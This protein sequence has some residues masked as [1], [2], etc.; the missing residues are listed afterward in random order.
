LQTSIIIHEQ[1]PQQEGEKECYHTKDVVLQEG[2]IE[3]RR[4]LIVQLVCSVE[5]QEG[6]AVSLNP[7][8]TRFLLL[9]LMMM[10]MIG[11]LMSVVLCIEMM[12]SI[13]IMQ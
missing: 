2:E 3:R 8:R 7:R 6:S 10:M 9:L 4:F 5:L 1:I 11:D 13:T 12:K